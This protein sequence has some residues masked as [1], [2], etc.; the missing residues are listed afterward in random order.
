MYRQLAAALAPFL[1]LAQ[2]ASIAQADDSRLYLAA[3]MG[4]S[5]PDALVSGVEAESGTNGDFGG[6]VG[7][8][9]SD[10][11][12]WDIAEA[13][14]VNFNGVDLGFG[15]SRSSVSLGTA[16][17]WGLFE[18]DNRYK[19]YVSLGLGTARLRYL[20]NATGQMDDDWAFEWNLGGG[21]DFVSTEDFRAGIRYRYR[22]SNRNTDGVDY[23][24]R[25]HSVSLEIAYLGGP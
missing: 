4:F 22:R 10:I 13:H 12:R 5:L 24:M 3:S 16:L 19:P 8:Q 9:T 21:V 7:V 25:A 1:L 17:N 23:G 11:F 18:S 6:A 14:F 20:S 15:A 2:M